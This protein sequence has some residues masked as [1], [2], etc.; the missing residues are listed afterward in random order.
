M[1]GG[2]AP[3]SASPHDL[4]IHDLRW[5]VARG[6]ERGGSLC[7][8]R[9]RD[10]ARALLALE[11]PPGL[12]IARLSA[13]VRVAYPVD[14]LGGPGVEDPAAACRALVIA[15]LLTAGATWTDRLA[16][17]SSSILAR[18]CAQR[19]LPTGGGRVARQA[20]LLEASPIPPTRPWV[21]WPH[22]ALLTRLERLATLRKEP[23]RGL[24]V[25]ERL[26]HVA[27]P[28]YTITPG[29]ASFAGR[30]ALLGW[31]A[32][33]EALAQDRLS[34]HEALEALRTG[35]GD[36]PGRLSLRRRL[37]R[38]V[39]SA[40][41]ELVRTGDPT[42]AHDLLAELERAATIAPGRLAV[43]RARC[44]ELAGDAGAALD[45]LRSR[46]PEA[47]VER[48]VA[49]DRSGRRL[50]RKLGRS[51]APAPPLR[52]AEDR[53]LRL[54]PAPADGPRPRWSVEGRSYAVEGAVRAVLARRGRVAL[55][56]E[57]GLATTLFA[58]IFA[59]ALFA[60]VPGALPV[61]QLDGPLDLGD[62]RFACRRAR[63]F[64]EGFD[65]I[66][67]GEAPDRVRAACAT[68]SGRRVAGVRGELDP[69][70]RWVE[71]AR[72]LGPRGLRAVLLPLARSGPRAAAGLPDLL[73]LPGPPIRLD[74]AFPRRVGP[75]PIFVEVKGP[76]DSLRDGQRVWIDRLLRAGS[77]VEVWRI[78]EDPS[79][80]RHRDDP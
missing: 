70:D 43:Q 65:A 18:W 24:L 46:A 16:G 6:L 79:A 35:A 8:D 51:W 47:T 13:R 10:V 15:G 37:S 69:P 5:V 40:A 59:E 75:G 26:G 33:Y 22:R 7:T 39:R 41:E 67:A 54:A 49:I 58:L 53:R 25:A 12:L 17:V 78:D 1:S 34:P 76:T 56:C 57:G 19:D 52:T 45:L 44:L 29:T 31:E 60:P 28:D 55:R 20:R 2:S 42:A 68:F 63:W 21:T 9:E 50:A 27:W 30:Q 72:A 14:E 3:A 74:G 71:A 36:G 61:P 32:L 77:V 38:A 64:F 66:A 73:V 23:D 11:G 48:R 62:A 4:P 80:T